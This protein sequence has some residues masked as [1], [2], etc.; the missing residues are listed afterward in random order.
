MANR[1]VDIDETFL[2][3]SIREQD[4]WTGRKGPGPA[5]QVE[6]RSK[7]VKDPVRHGGGI[8]AD[9]SSRFLGRNEFKGRRCVYISE[10][11]HATILEIVKILSGREVTV[12]G[13]IDAILT[14]HLEAHRDEIIGL[15]HGE[16]SKKSGKGLLEF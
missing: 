15:Y 1:K 14:A 16:L 3:S 10:R 9:Y 5:A 13:Y 8:P 2:L 4:A 11:I 6:E 12:G 7:G